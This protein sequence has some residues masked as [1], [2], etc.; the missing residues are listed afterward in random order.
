MRNRPRH[1]PRR[2]SYFL[3]RDAVHLSSSLLLHR[4]SPLPAVHGQGG[5]TASSPHILTVAPSIAKDLV[6]APRHRRL[7]TK[8]SNLDSSPP[9]PPPAL[10]LR[11]ARCHLALPIPPRLYH[12]LPLPPPPPSSLLAPPSGILFSDSWTPTAPYALLFAAVGRVA[13]TPGA[14]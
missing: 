14:L 3:R 8:K 1:L 6:R 4:P 2:G 9:P 12:C 11:L 13:L 5:V 10:N 7:K